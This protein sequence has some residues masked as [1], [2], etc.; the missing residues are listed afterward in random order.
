VL[1]S[2]TGAESVDMKE[3]RPREQV[4]NRWKAWRDG[5]STWQLMAVIAGVT[6]FI[7]V[8]TSCV[9]RLATGHFNPGQSI[10][11]GFIFAAASLFTRAVNR[12]D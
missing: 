8:G 1:R 10:L 3:T 5:L 7:I 11:Y 2:K 6:I 9:Y 12:R 4:M